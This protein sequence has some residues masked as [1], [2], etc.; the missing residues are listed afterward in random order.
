MGPKKTLVMLLVTI[1]LQTFA[2]SSNDNPKVETPPVAQASSEGPQVRLPTVVAPRLSEA[3][4]AVNRVFKKA[5]VVDTDYSPA[6]LTGDF[7]GDLTEDLAVVLKVSP[8]KISEM[9]EQYPAWLLRD[10]FAPERSQLSVKEDE[11]LLAIIH[12]HGDNNWR[13]LQAT[14]TF[15]LKNSV[16]SQIEVHSLKDQS[17]N[18]SKRRVPRTQGD[19]IAEEIRGSSGYLY[20]SRST[21]LWFDPKNPTTPTVGM[22]HRMR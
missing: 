1:C 15:L 4:D 6:F 10:P 22:V 21:Y 16:G 17:T 7:N 20:Y 3:Q 8:G 19:L 13:D 5:V 12:G 18:K 2:C 14:Q 11:R 9:N